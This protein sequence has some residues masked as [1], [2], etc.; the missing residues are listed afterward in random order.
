MGFSSVRRMMI[1]IVGL[2]MLTGLVGILGVRF[3]DTTSA[4]SPMPPLNVVENNVDADGN[5]RVH[6]QGTVPVSGTVNVGNTPAVQNVSVTNASLPVTGS[7]SV[8]NFPAAATGVTHFFHQ[9]V[10]PFNAEQILHIDISKFSKVRMAVVVNGTGG[11]VD[12][13]W[14]TN[15]Q[16]ADNFS[17]DTGNQH[18]V[19]LGDVAGTDLEV[20]LESPNGQQVF[21]DVFGSN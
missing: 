3:S 7:V 5:I 12:F 4:A 17:V 13:F 8:S 1:A 21:V 9:E 19:F 16:I 14:G 18:T 10:F 20:D 2:V 15:A 11:S 6:E